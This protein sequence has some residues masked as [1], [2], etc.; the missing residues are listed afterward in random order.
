[1]RV[2]PQFLFVGRPTS[3][4]RDPA[5]TIKQHDSFCKGRSATWC[6]TASIDQEPRER[7]QQPAL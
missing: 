3:P 2:P 6:R 5:R 1:M 7:G 4:P